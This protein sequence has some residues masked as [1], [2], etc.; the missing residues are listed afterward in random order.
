MA[1]EGLTPFLPIQQVPLPLQNPLIVRAGQSILELLGIDFTLGQGEAYQQALNMLTNNRDR[2]RDIIGGSLIE[3]GVPQRVLTQMIDLYLRDLTLAGHGQFATISQFSYQL[4]QDL[5]MLGTTESDIIALVRDRTRREVDI[6]ENFNYWLNLISW[7]FRLPIPRPLELA[8]NRILVYLTTRM[9]ILIR[10]NERVQHIQSP[11]I[12][13]QLSFLISSLQF[14]ITFFG[15]KSAATIIVVIF[16][17]IHYADP[18]NWN[19]QII[20]FIANYTGL[21]ITKSMNEA[22][23]AGDNYLLELKKRNEDRQNYYAKKT[24]DDFTEGV[25]EIKKGVLSLINDPL[26]ENEYDADM[27]ELKDVLDDLTNIDKNINEIINIELPPEIIEPI[28]NNQ[29]MASQEEVDRIKRISGMF[30]ESETVE[31]M[32]QLK[33]NYEDLTGAYKSFKGAVSYITSPYLDKPPSYSID[34]P[35]N[36]GVPGHLGKSGDGVEKGGAHPIPSVPDEPPV[37]G[38]HNHNKPA[39]EICYVDKSGNAVYQQAAHNYGS[40]NAPNYDYKKELR[41]NLVKNVVQN[42]KLNRNMFLQ[43]IPDDTKAGIEYQRQQNTAQELPN[44]NLQSMRFSGIFDPQPVYEPL[45]MYDN[46]FKFHE[47]QLNPYEPL[48]NENT[49][50]EPID[51]YGVRRANQIAKG[52]IY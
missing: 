20:D 27:K 44:F 42:D 9:N 2:L 43:S 10:I 14:L 39:F 1:L 31:Q 49:P 4:W 8:L 25:E 34:T 22:L 19:P 36:P 5:R 32:L 12:R 30:G 38:L 16:G 23:E 18:R 51:K 48:Y 13:L 37:K 7:F 47:R 15:S 50:Y 6:N 40:T 33:Q 24:I 21:N 26:L 3:Q 11:G 45:P 17:I 28:K 52:A 41:N 35:T 46:R 29:V